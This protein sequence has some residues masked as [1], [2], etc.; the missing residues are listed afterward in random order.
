MDG[1]GVRKLIIEELYKRRKESGNRFIEIDRLLNEIPL[2]ESTFIKNALYLEKLGLVEML[3]EGEEFLSA[4]RIT[5]AG[6]VEMESRHVSL[7]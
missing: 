5:F 6:V 4:I 3:I 7:T 2:D 1:P